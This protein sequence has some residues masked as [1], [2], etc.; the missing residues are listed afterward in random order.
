MDQDYLAPDA[1]V[2]HVGVTSTG[3]KSI[4]LKNK[5]QNFV[6]SKTGM[7]DNWPPISWVDWPPNVGQLA[8]SLIVLMTSEHQY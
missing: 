1:G 6:L 4:I 2:S 5:C 7:R 3:N 8:A